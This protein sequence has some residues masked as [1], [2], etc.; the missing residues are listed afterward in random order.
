M[1]LWACQPAGSGLK[2]RLP[3]DFSL[4]PRPVLQGARRYALSDHRGAITEYAGEIFMRR[5][6]RQIIHVL[7]HGEVRFGDECRRH[8]D[9]V[10][11]LEPASRC[12]ISFACPAVGNQPQSDRLLE[13]QALWSRSA[14]RFSRPLLIRMARACSVCFGRRRVQPCGGA[15]AWKKRNLE[16]LA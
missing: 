14:A 13:P 5:H 3:T 7:L 8:E 2:C 15:L 10:E 1:Y 6:G 12:S 4:R 16:M 11:W 9:N